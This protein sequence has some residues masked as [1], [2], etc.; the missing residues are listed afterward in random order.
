[1][2][3]PKVQSTV[4]PDKPIPTCS[5]WW[6]WLA[7]KSKRE[8]YNRFHKL[9][10]M[11]II[12]IDYYSEELGTDY[13]MDI[14]IEANVCAVDHGI[15]EYEFWGTKGYHTDV[16]PEVNDIYVS[17]L[18]IYDENSKS[19]EVTKEIEKLVDKWIVAN[20]TRIEDA[21]LEKAKIDC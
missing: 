4:Y 12:S 18:I 2:S 3:K 17:S 20:S 8:W 14:E 10:I 1:M 16:R 9:G 6:Q 15:G 5:Y 13:G 19:V 11:E 7:A 21:I